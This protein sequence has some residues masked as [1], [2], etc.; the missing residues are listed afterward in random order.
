[1]ITNVRRLF[2]DFVHGQRRATSREGTSRAT[3][4]DD[5]GGD[6]NEADDCGGG[7]DCGEAGLAESCGGLQPAGHKEAYGDFH[8]CI[9]GRRLVALLLTH[10][11]CDLLLL[12]A[13]VAGL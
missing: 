12:S 2:R 3:A 7:G 8:R 10:H 1:M 6:C 13:C 5:G 9:N 4:R 11:S